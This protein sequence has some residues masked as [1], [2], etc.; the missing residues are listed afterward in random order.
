M[1]ESEFHFF[2]CCTMY[3]DLRKKYLGNTSLPTINMF[4]CLMSTKSSKK[5]VNIAKFIKEANVLRSNSLV[6]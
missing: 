6:S 2:L 5:L 3:Q 4:E 1:I